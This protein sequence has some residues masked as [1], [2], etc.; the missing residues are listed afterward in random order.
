MFEMA[1]RIARYW[2]FTICALAALIIIATPSYG[3]AQEN[4]AHGI[5]HTLYLAIRSEDPNLRVLQQN[6]GVTPRATLTVT[7]RIT[8]H[9]KE[10]D[11]DKDIS[12]LFEFDPIIGSSAQKIWQDAACHR[13]RGFPKITILGVNGTIASGEQRSSIAAS[14]RKIGFR[15]PIDEVMAAGRMN[16]GSDNRGSFIDSQTDTKQSRLVVEDKLYISLC[17]LK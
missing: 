2:N 6:S 13:E 7:V 15:L 16:F 9:S 17:E 14:D 1:R 12:A 5:R 8:D 4:S 3:R 11:F 10:A